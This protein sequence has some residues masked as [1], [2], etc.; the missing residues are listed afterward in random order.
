[1]TAYLEKFAEWAATLTIEDIPEDVRTTISLQLANALAAARAGTTATWLE[2]PRSDGAATA[3]GGVGAT[4]EDAAFTNA[5]ASMVHDYDDYCF[6]GH[7]GHSAVFAPLALCDR[8]GLDGTDLITTIAIANELEGRLGGAA[9]LGP[10]NGQMWAFIHQAGAAAVAGRIVGGD[11]ETIADSVRMG[12]Y[13]T[14]FPTDAGF[15]DSDAKALTAAAPTATGLRIRAAA[16]RG[17]SGSPAA[18]DSF[19]ETYA[20]VPFPEMLT[21]FGQSWV[22]RTLCF[23]PRPGCAYVQ[24]PWNVLAEIDERVGLEAEQVDSI[25]G[26]GTADHLRYGVSPRPYRQPDRLLPVTVTFSVEY[27]LALH[28][29]AGGVEPA[30][31]TDEYIETHR[32]ELDQLASR[33]TLEHDWGQTARMVDGHECRGRLLATDPRPGNS[34]NPR[35]LLAVRQSSPGH[36]PRPRGSAPTEVRRTRFRHRL[37][38]LAAQLES[39]RSG[40]G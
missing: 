17:A 33:V 26:Q 18:L 20:Y 25:D 2:P 7:T 37:V 29:L 28:L 40:S 11:A 4:V 3:L 24:T 12:L 30:V 23:K 35:R 15:M 16:A 32:R 36:S 8:E 14:P 21:G 34:A 13:S 5:A 38:P 19:L 39:I 27:S 10:H 31:L 6:M 1:M 22:S 9:A